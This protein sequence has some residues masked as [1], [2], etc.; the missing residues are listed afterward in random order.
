MEGIDRAMCGNKKMGYHDGLRRQTLKYVRNSA[1]CI[2]PHENALVSLQQVSH[3][4]LTILR[5]NPISLH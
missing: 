3:P 1:L 4:L 2:T 5:Q